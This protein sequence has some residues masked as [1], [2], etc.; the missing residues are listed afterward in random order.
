MKVINF[1]KKQTNKFCSDQTIGIPFAVGE[2]SFE[3]EA[4]EQEE[5]L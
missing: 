3:T 1:F 2:K 5:D 4:P